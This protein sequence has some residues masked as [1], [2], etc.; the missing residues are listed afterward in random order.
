MQHKLLLKLPPN[1]RIIIKER[2][3][4]S[5]FYNPYEVRKII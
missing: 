2:K 1:L 3:S 4:D 5:G